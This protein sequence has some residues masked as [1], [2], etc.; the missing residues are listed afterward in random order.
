MK[1]TQIIW[2][3][4]ITVL[5][6][7]LSVQLITNWQLR[8][9]TEIRRLQQQ[10]FEAQN[11]VPSIQEIQQRLCYSGY[12]V[13]VDGIWG[14]ETAEALKRCVCDRHASEYFGPEE[15]SNCYESIGD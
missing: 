11:Y 6:I 9:E 2:I 8:Y 3:G 12:P 13:K 15:D 7:G 1:T 14:K 4:F 5:L 10:L